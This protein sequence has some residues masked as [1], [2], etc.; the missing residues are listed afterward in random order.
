MQSNRK[1]QYHLDFYRELLVMA[2]CFRSD[3]FQHAQFL[4]HAA[5]ARQRY[6][7]CKRG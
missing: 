2:R 6:L 1:P 3:R 4:H 7:S 5:L